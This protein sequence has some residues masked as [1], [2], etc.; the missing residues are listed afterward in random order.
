MNSLFKSLG[1]ASF[2]PAERIATGALNPI[3]VPRVP[4]FV[5]LFHAIN[6]LNTNDRPFILQFVASVHGEGTSTIA[7]SFVEV[8]A[9]SPSAKR[10][11]LVDC[12]PDAEAPARAKSLVPSLIDAFHEFGSVDVAIKWARGS[13]GVG[14][15]RLSSGND[16]LLNIS[17]GD[18][19]QLF[20]LV[21]QSFPIIVFDCPPAKEAPESLAL[22]RYCDGTV[23]VV[24][25]ESTPR[26]IVAATKQAV[27]RFGGQIIGVVFNQ[28]STYIPIWLDRWLG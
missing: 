25:A 22:A 4:Q 14:L 18:L 1:V 11:L 21:M 19:R 12:N 15:T 24:R 9:G 6:A 20:D 10:A 23:L 7:T 26:P 13:P 8:V 5:Q 3:S 28:C 27:E 16:S 17:A 2:A